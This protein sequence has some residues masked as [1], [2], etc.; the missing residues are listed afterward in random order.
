MRRA[1]ANDAE[2]CSRSSEPN[3]TRYANP[4]STPSND[5]SNDKSAADDEQYDREI[6][7]IDET[8]FYDVS[9][10]CWVNSN[11]GSIVTMP[12]GGDGEV[13]GHDSKF[14]APSRMRASILC[15]SFL[16]LIAI[17]IVVVTTSSPTLVTNISGR[18]FAVRISAGSAVP[19]VDLDG[20]KWLPD[21][22]DGVYTHYAVEGKGLIYESCPASIAGAGRAGPGLYCKERNFDAGGQYEIFVPASG[23]YDVSLHF[24]EVYFDS[25]GERLFDI[26]VE[27]D[28]VRHD[29]DIVAAA[30]GPRKALLVT[31]TKVSVT[32]GALT[33]VLRSKK[34]H[35][36]ISGIEVKRRSD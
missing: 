32:D 25:A 8:D 13:Y 27:G 26:L 4:C 36:K 30:A 9:D 35:A 15:S 19:Y 20:N 31:A 22:E 1:D 6:D 28:V 24:A 11:D 12:N 14:F 2:D 16:L 23:L 18:D 21:S 34:D 5:D 10:G 17:L 7:I 33:I 29:L 3:R